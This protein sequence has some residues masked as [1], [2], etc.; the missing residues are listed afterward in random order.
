MCA[1]NSIAKF[2]AINN[3]IGKIHKLKTRDKVVV[4]AV[5]AGCVI[6]TLMYFV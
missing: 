5:L 2:P 3:V 4:A 6:V 1:Q